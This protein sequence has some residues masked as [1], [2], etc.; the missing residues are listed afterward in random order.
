MDSTINRKVKTTE[1]KKVK[2]HSLIH[3]TS[4]V[5]GTL[6][7]RDGIRKINKQFNYSHKSTQ[8]KQQVD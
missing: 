3:N 7:F 4:G 2:M 1:G 6:E 5:K 8:P